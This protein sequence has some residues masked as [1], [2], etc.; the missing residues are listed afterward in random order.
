[1]HKVGGREEE[2]QKIIFL[3]NKLADYSGSSPKK[4]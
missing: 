3:A 1:L 4:N 2:V